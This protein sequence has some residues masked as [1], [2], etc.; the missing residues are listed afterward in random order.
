[1]N[2]AIAICSAVFLAAV[3]WMIWEIRHA[4]LC[5]RDGYP[6]KPPADDDEDDPD[7]D[8]EYHCPSG[9]GRTMERIQL[10]KGTPESGYT[11]LLCSQCGRLEC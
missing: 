8:D 1:M 10:R 7:P 4:P 3:A 5:D 9:C 11:G 2:V 6:V